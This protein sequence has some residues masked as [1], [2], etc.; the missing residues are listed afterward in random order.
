MSEKLIRGVPQNLNY[1]SRLDWLFFA[2][3]VI[4]ILAL[5]EVRRDGRIEERPDDNF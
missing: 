5:S 4:Q 2:C 1:A 3:Y